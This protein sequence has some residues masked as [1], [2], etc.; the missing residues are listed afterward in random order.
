MW[1]NAPRLL[2]RRSLSSSPPP[3][4]GS[5][6]P[7]PPPLLYPSHKPL[8]HFAK[9]GLFLKSSLEAASDPTNADAV[10]AILD[11]S[12]PLTLTHLHKLMSSSKTGSRILK[13]QPDIATALSSSS[14][15]FTSLHYLPPS[16]FG[17]AY[18]TFM[19]HHHFA[20]ENRPAVKYVDDEQL[21]YILLRY[22]LSHDFYHTIYNLPPT[23]PGELVLKMIETLEFKLG[24]AALQAIVGISPMTELLT[25]R[26][27]EEV[28]EV[29]VPWV[30]ENWKRRKGMET[31]LNVYWEEELETDI[32]GLRNDLNI[33]KAPAFEA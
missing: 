25:K 8:P 3:F 21:A 33:T 14:P 28:M 31:L 12:S 11:I 9:L 22:R 1:L 24:G 13:A 7:P 6:R 2:L 20:S 17:K 18:H 23:V 16:T 27:R 19:D 4:Y 26:E 32:E 30:V 15:L 29:F 5:P 10:G